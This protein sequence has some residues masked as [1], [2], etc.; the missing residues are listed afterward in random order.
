MK[1]FGDF[2]VGI[3]IADVSHYV[4]PFNSE[5]YKL[6]QEG[7][8]ASFGYKTSSCS[9]R[10]RERACLAFAKQN[11]FLF[12]PCGSIDDLLRQGASQGCFAIGEANFSDHGANRLGA[13]ALD[14]SL[15]GSRINF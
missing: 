14:T 6:T 12:Q 10:L 1:R 7:L 11:Y 4:K 8:M 13:S 9:L 3:H 15:E 2:E 5:D